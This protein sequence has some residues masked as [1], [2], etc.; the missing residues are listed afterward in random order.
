LSSG[1]SSRTQRKLSLE[2]WRLFLKLWR[3]ILG[4]RRLT[5]ELLKFILK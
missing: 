2:Q 1:G 5:L 3:V 4:K